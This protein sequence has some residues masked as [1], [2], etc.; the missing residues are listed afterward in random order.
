MRRGDLRREL[1]RVDLA[2]EGSLPASLEAAIDVDGGLWEAGD[3]Y[4]DPAEIVDAALRVGA[5]ALRLDVRDLSLLEQLPDVRYLHVRSD[6][7]PVLDP[8]AGLR[9]L[10]AL[11]LDTSALR[12]ELDPLAFPE[13]RWLR[14]GLGGKG[15]ARVLPSIVRG[16]AAL[17]WLALRETRA[18][19]VEELVGAF[20]S[21]RRISIHFAD[22]IARLGHLGA[23]TPRLTGINLWLTQL[24]S[25]DGIEALPEL[26]MLSVVG[27]QVRDLSP[28]A[29]ARRLRYARLLVPRTDSIEPLAGHPA[30][31]MLELGI[32]RQPS[33]A[34]LDSIPGLVAVGRGRGFEGPIS[35]ADLFE[36]PR[37]DPLRIEWV[38]ESRA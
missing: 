19:S 28:V 34:V 37:D 6:G 10:R 7:R 5:V 36:L 4:T 20:P 11:L 17:E 18:R 25:L 38:R 1:R 9:G 32:G 13:L 3:Y 35:Q 12:G 26:E 21:L 27:G 15:G 33:T 29:A 31:R 24:A 22:Y 8:I 14:V 23:T 16:H 2:T 30:L